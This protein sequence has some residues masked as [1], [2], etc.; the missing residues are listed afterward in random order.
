MSSSRPEFPGADQSQDFFGLGFEP[1]S[2]PVAY[3]RLNATEL[4]EVEPF[5]ERCAIAENDPLLSAGDYPFSGYVI[6]SGTVRA[7]DISTG[8]RAVFVRYGAGYFTG[9]IGWLSKSRSNSWER[10]TCPE[11]RRGI[12]R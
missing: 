7:V 2:D 11:Q 10:Q 5:G 4:A 6:L 12:S 9:D 1:L 8:E 3:P